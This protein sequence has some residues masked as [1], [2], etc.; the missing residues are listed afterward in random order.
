[1]LNAIFTV[2][3]A[4]G[5]YIFTSTDARHRQDEQINTTRWSTQQVEDSRRNERIAV[6]ENEN[7]NLREVLIRIEGRSERLELKVDQLLKR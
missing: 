6:L 3:V 1:M 5:G 4:V 2:A 7:R